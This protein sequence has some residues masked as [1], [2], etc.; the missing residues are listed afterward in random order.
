MTAK[1]SLELWP[2]F[3]ETIVSS[4]VCMYTNLEMVPASMCW[5][6][7]SAALISPL[8]HQTWQIW[9]QFYRTYHKNYVS[10]ILSNKSKN[11]SEQ[12]YQSRSRLYSCYVATAARMHHARQTITRHT[13]T[14]SSS[15]MESITKY[16]LTFVTDHCCLLQSRSSSI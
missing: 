16:M 11:A 8:I 13:R 2:H 3:Q 9:T 14:C 10:T 12:D 1:M 5:C 15:H 7:R 4:R 6:Q